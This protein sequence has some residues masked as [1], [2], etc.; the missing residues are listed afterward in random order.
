MYKMI[1]KQKGK[2]YEVHKRT[3]KKRPS[4]FGNR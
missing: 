1:I 2:D 4:C 3:I